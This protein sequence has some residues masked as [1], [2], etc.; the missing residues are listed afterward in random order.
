MQI[1]KNPFEVEHNQCVL[2]LKPE[3]QVVQI[4][5]SIVNVVYTHI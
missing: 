4:S 5:V 3:K 1:V 2:F